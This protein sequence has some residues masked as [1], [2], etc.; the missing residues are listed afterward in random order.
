LS[1]SERLD[2]FVFEWFGADAPAQLNLGIGNNVPVEAA[3]AVIA[4]YAVGSAPPVHLYRMDK[5]DD[6]GNTHRVYV[7]G[8]Q[9]HAREPMKAERIKALLDP[10]LT[11]DELMKLIPRATD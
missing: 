1:D 3:Q 6:F 5:D 9:S 2:R 4:A 11:R 8:L 7:G 10:L